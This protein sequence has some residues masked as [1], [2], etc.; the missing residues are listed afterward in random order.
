VKILAVDYIHRNLSL[1]MHSHKSQD[2]ARV[3]EMIQ[4]AKLKQARKQVAC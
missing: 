4:L 3:Q 1:M 2:G